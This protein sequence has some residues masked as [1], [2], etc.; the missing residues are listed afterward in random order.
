MGKFLSSMNEMSSLFI[1]FYHRSQ[2]ETLK[3]EILDQERGLKCQIATLE[4]KAHE[5]WVSHSI[6]LYLGYITVYFTN[7]VFRNM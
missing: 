1:C 2:N 7:L 4:K 3:K 5:N 6:I